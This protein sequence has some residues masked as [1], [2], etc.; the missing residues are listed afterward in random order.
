MW[1]VDTSLKCQQSLSK[2]ITGWMDGSKK[3]L[4]RS[5]WIDLHWNESFINQM[6][7]RQA[8]RRNTGRSKNSLS[9]V[10]LGFSWR[11]KRND[12][13]IALPMYFGQFLGKVYCEACCGGVKS[14]M[15]C[16]CINCT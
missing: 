11:I 12:I 14:G 3:R 9:I 15:L 1:N 4:W 5:G 7:L 6:Q 10:L 16:F 13:I 8:V 2:N